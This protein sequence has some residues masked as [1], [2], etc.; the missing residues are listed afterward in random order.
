MFW[1]EP[2]VTN[3]Y[4]FHF[5]IRGCGCGKR[6]AFPAPSIRERDNEIAEPGQ[7][8]AECVV[9]FSRHCEERSDESNPR[10]RLRRYGLLRFARNDAGVLFEV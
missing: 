4:A 9:L 7:K 5:R 3:S 8:R 1:P 6:P 2:V 10:F